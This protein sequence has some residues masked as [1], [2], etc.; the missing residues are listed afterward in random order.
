M[1]GGADQDPVPVEPGGD[2][3]DNRGHRML[4]RHHKT[5][6]GKRALNLFSGTDRETDFSFLPPIRRPGGNMNK[7]KKVKSRRK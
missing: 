4:L 6:S 5:F 1:Y 2:P 3:R 7:K